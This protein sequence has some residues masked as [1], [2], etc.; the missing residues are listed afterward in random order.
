MSANKRRSCKSNNNNNNDNSNTA[1][2]IDKDVQSEECQGVPTIDVQRLCRCCGKGDME[3][4]KLFDESAETANQKAQTQFATAQI[5]QRQ[6]TTTGE[7]AKIAQKQH[8]QEQQQQEKQQQQRKSDNPVEYALSG[9]HSSMD[10]VLEEMI[11]WTLNISRDDGLPQEICRQCKAQF[12]MVAK[13]RRRCVRVQQRLHDYV[14][15]MI[16]HKS[17]REEERTQ[18]SQANETS[19]ADYMHLPL[20]QMERK[21]R[22]VPNT[23]SSSLPKYTKTDATQLLTSPKLRRM[24]LRVRNIRTAS[25]PAS[26]V[27]TETEAG[28]T[29]TTSA[30]RL[31]ETKQRTPQRSPYRARLIHVPWK[32]KAARKQISETWSTSLCETDSVTPELPKEQESAN[33]TVALAKTAAEA[34]PNSLEDLSDLSVNICR[35]FDNDNGSSSTIVSPQPTTNVK[36]SFPPKRCSPNKT[37]VLR[38]QDRRCY[39]PVKRT[40]RVV[41][42]AKAATEAAKVELCCAEVLSSKTTVTTKA[43]DQ[44]PNSSANE[45]PT[46]SSSSIS[47]TLESPE[48]SIVDEQESKIIEKAENGMP[49]TESNAQQ[50]EPQVCSPVSQSENTEE[51]LQ[52]DEAIKCSP[53]TLGNDTQDK[54]LMEQMESIS[55]EVIK[56]E[57]EVNGIVETTLMSPVQLEELSSS[58][59]DHMERERRQSGTPEV[60]AAECEVEVSLTNE[61]QTSEQMSDQTSDQLSEQTS[62]LI[63]SI[64]LDALGEDLQRKLC[65]ESEPVTNELVDE[66]K[67]PD[68]ELKEPVEADDV[69][70]NENGENFCQ[71]ATA[72]S[73]NAAVALATKQIEAEP[74]GGGDGDDDDDDDDMESL[75]KLPNLQH[76]EEQ[77][78]QHQQQPRA[79]A[80][81]SSMDFLAEFEK[82]C[83]K[84]LKPQAA[85]QELAEAKQQL[86]VE[87]NDVENT[88]HGILNEMQDEHLYTPVCTPI[89]EFLTPA[90]Y[91]PPTPASPNLFEQPAEAQ[92]PL[93]SL[94]QQQQQ[95]KEGNLFD[96]STFSNELIGFQNDMPCFENIESTPESM[97]AQQSLQLELTQLFNELQPAQQQQQQQQQQQSTQQ[98]QQQQ[99]QLQQE[100]VNY[101][102]LYQTAPLPVAN[103]NNNNKLQVIQMTPQETLW[104]AQ[105]AQQ[106]QQPLEQPQ[107]T[108]TTQLQWSTVGGLEAI[109][110]TPSLD[111]LD[112]SNSNNNNNSNTTTSTTTT[113]YYINA[114]DLYQTQQ[115]Q[116]QPIESY[117]L[118]DSNDNYVLEQQQQ[119][120]QHQHQQP[121]QQQPIMILIQQPELQQPVASASNPQQAPLHINYS[122]EMQAYQQQQQQHSHQPQ[123]HPKPQAHPRPQQV[124]NTVLGLP[125]VV[126]PPTRGRPPMLKCRFCQNGPRFSSSLEYS[127][128]IIELHPFVAPFNCPH[129]SLAFAG[130]SQRNQHILSSHIVQQFHCGQCSQMFPSQRALDLHLQRLHMPLATEPTSASASSGTASAGVRLEEVQLR[131][132]TT[133]DLQQQQQQQQRQHQRQPLQQQSVA[134]MRAL[135]LQTSPS[136]PR[137]TRILCCPDC[138]DCTSASGHTQCSVQ[139]YEELNT[140]QPPPTVLTPPSTIASLPSPHITLPSPEQS[141]PDSTTATLRQFR[142]R[143]TVNSSTTAGAAIAAATAAATVATTTTTMLTTTA[144]SPSP[145]SSPSSSTMETSATLQLGKLRGTH[146]CVI[147]EKRFTN[148]IALRKHQQLAHDSQ[149]TMPWVCSICKRGYR[150]RT[151]MDNHMKSHEPKG[152]PYECNECWVRFP[153]FKQLAMHKF[154]VH[155]LIKPHT[156]D[157]CGKQFGTESALK[158]HIKFHGVHMNTH[159]PLGVFLNDKMPSSVCSKAENPSNTEESLLPLT[160]LSNCNGNSGSNSGLE[161][162]PGSVE[163]VVESSMAAPSLDMIVDTP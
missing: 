60:P 144:A 51:E 26:K 153:E 117:A 76:E 68:G 21:R 140:L 149:T 152:R 102:A 130:R 116:Q 23:E 114:S 38:R 3:L 14:Q 161:D 103:N 82:H 123:P 12:I 74:N 112:S 22:L 96:S 141:E 133:N 79:S 136:R 105:A 47:R 146:Q 119:Q 25:L 155:E 7:K 33:G 6:K 163:M 35:G 147:C 53:D 134:H 34:D 139:P 145:S 84:S 78:Q 77:Q 106:Q 159:L 93:Q 5:R 8:Q 142:K 20:S 86:A 132:A 138:E 111:N 81:A 162:C 50:E 128:H 40:R 120:Q 107:A 109:K 70:N 24:Q 143:C 148:V 100:T 9:A 87:M 4:L 91:A 75:E 151:D 158:T 54:M 41:K 37:R 80:N 66:L 31:S 58:G 71:S 157:E 17:Q 95:Q 69:N 121:Q 101:E 72:D 98:Q 16:E 97:A 99:L 19:A 124:Q 135:E 73:F 67:K 160:P 18:Q 43:V 122:N 46:S 125:A 63:V 90:D 62:E 1:D 126:P 83:E 49:E 55:E 150:K 11:I 52:P 59:M 15:D 32:T 154:T 108:P 85:G 129:C 65:N 115:Q 110:T 42:K 89:D 10:I 113:T 56:A 64:P 137:R 127:R 104:Q 92:Q 27:E 2:Q 29:K 156:C 118:L 57:G 39:A 28:A 36:R 44:M 13:F 61:E 88:L 45:G 30:C 131:I 48:I 94:Q